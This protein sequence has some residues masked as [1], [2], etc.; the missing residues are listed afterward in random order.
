MTGRNQRKRPL[1]L[2]FVRSQCGR[3]NSAFTIQRQ[4]GKSIQDNSGMNQSAPE[5][6]LTEVFV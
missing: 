3:N 6:K 5:H 1:H 4:T 2:A